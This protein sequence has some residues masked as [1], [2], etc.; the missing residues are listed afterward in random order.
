MWDF[1][2]QPTI[3]FKNLYDAI[4]RFIN[5]ADSFYFSVMIN[6]E[7]AQYYK[8]LVVNSLGSTY[9]KITKS[10]DDLVACEVHEVNKLAGSVVITLIGGSGVI[11]IC[12]LVLIYHLVILEKKYSEYWEFVRKVTLGCYYNL[13][14]A[15]IERLSSVH[16]ISNQQDEHLKVSKTLNLPKIKPKVL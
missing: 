2:D 7:Y 10:L 13:K 15:S 9:D 16:G 3:E 5:Q 4:A 14:N 6:E 8:F 1:K 12:L 11:V